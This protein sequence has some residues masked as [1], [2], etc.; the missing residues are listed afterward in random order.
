[1]FKWI[2]SFIVFLALV[3]I[4][5]SGCSQ[6]SNNV[7]IENQKL[8]SEV[9]QLQLKVEEKNKQIEQYNKEYYNDPNEL[10]TKIKN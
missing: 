9:E 3:T 5:L 8:R 2:R 10:N 6:K 1:M 4:V 7:E